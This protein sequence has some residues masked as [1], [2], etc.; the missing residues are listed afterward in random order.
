T[1]ATYTTYALQTKAFNATVTNA[2]NTDV[3]WSVTSGPG[4][5]DANG[6]YTAPSLVLSVQSAI[7]TATSQADPN[8]TFSATI[9]LNPISVTVPPSSASL[10]IGG[11]KQF[12]ANV[13]NSD[14][15]GV[16]WTVSGPGTISTGG[17]Y[18]APVSIASGQPVTITAASVADPAKTGTATVTLEPVTV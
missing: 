8:K 18:T 17:L 1:P 12:T 5:I 11:T 10:D 4:T 7:I 16:T 6:V 3:N 9:T 2:D 14:N 13:V 15:S